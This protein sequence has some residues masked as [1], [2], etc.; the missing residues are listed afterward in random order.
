MANCHSHP[1]EIKEVQYSQRSGCS[2]SQY[3]LSGVTVKGQFI[4]DNDQTLI[5]LVEC[6]T[7]EGEPERSARAGLASYP[8]LQIAGGRPGIHCLRMRLI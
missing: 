1:I 2:A 8:G 5:K 6:R 4:T 3:N 7:L